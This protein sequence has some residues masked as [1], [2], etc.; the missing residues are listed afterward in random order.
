MLASTLLAIVS[1]LAPPAASIGKP[2]AEGLRANAADHIAE[3]ELSESLG[4][5]RAA[6]AVPITLQT[7]SHHVDRV[8]LGMGKSCPFDNDEL[9]FQTEEPLFTA[10]ECAAVRAEAAAKIAAGAGS[11]FTMT[12]TN[13]DCAVHDLPQTL[14]WLNGGALGRVASLAATCF[15]SAVPSAESLWIY[16]GLVIS[17]DAA[18][19]L[20]HQPIHRDGA[21]ISCVVPLSARDEYEGGGTYVEPLGQAFALDQGCA[22]L[23]PSAVRHAGHRITSGHRWVLVLFLN[24]EEMHE[25]E[26]GRRFRARAQEYFAASQE[27]EEEEEGEEQEGEDLDDDEEEEEEEEEWEDADGEDGDEELE[28]LLHALHATDESDHEVWYDL[29]ARAHDL[30]DADEALRLYERAVAL[31][32]RDPLL[33][34]NMGVALLELGRP[35]EA[36]RCYRKALAADPHSVNARFNAGELLLELGK[37]DGLAALLS[38]APEDAMQDEGLMSLKAE[39]E[40]ARE[41]Q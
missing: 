40:S 29:G 35:R 1:A 32:S 37:L 4:F 21:L 15:P 8:A 5:R 36:F 3:R 17:Y 39:L 11:T 14:A 33:L 12:N 23:H 28:C 41:P 34:S 38:Q 7:R 2:Y 20:T 30:G 27:E 31:N 22:L 6:A 26:H 9:I 16:R 13:R 18:A 24:R 10:S 19:G 25:G